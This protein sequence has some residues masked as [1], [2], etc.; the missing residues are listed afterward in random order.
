MQKAES[1]SYVNVQAHVELFAYNEVKL[2]AC[3]L[4]DALILGDW[5]FFSLLYCGFYVYQEL[6]LCRERCIIA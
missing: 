3:I 5:R 1:M 4:Q 2:A 6:L